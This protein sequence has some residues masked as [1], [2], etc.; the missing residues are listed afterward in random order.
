MYPTMKL[1]LLLLAFSQRLR[2]VLGQF[3]SPAIPDDTGVVFESQNVSAAS[4]IGT[5]SVL[6]PLR[7]KTRYTPDV[8]GF[9]QD[10]GNTRTNDW[11]GPLGNS[12]VVYSRSVAISAQYWHDDNRL[13]ARSVCGNATAAH[14]CIAAFHPETMDVLATW[15]PEKQTL[16]SPYAT[17]MDNSIL[18]P[19]VEGHVIQVERLDSANITSFRQLRDIDLTSFLPEGHAVSISYPD[20]DENVWFV[21]TRLSSLGN[22]EDSSIIGYVASTGLVRTL[23]FDGQKIEN[24][25]AVNGKTVYVNTG[26]LASETNGSNTGH[27][28][29][30][31]VD[32]SSGKIQAAWNETYTAGSSAKPGGFSRG[33]GS[34]PALVGDKFVVMTDNADIQV[35]LV[36]Y[37]Q[38]QNEPEGLGGNSSFVC[39]VPLFQPNAS[40]NENAMVGYFDG[41]TYSVIINNNYGA[42]ELQDL[43]DTN[44]INGRY[45]DFASLA[46]GI[47]RVD[48]SPDGKCEVRWTQQVRSTSVLSLSTANGLVYSYTQDERLAINGEYVWYFTAIDFQTGE[49]VWRVRSGAGGNYN[50]NV[51]PTQMSPNGAIYQVIAGGVTWLKDRPS[52]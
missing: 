23:R 33:S 38:V 34:T 5:P 12:P 10:G 42:P 48:I 3:A 20:E 26:P 46:P 21:S 28:Y 32:T 47:T 19:T 41:S 50:N 9:H 18:I 52:V 4:F 43:R 1:G 49:L 44:N 24:S 51:A 39:Q 35:N 15:V 36:V 8:V 37:R 14:F 7:A 25:I 2:P 27:M 30:L 6:M 22:I 17:I 45:N 29:A 13:T 11:P 40:A 31:Q 16:L